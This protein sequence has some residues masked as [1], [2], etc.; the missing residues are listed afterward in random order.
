MHSVVDYRVVY[1]PVEHVA[2]EWQRGVVVEDGFDV[3]YEC[4]VDAQLSR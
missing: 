4:F 3:T 2:T 1:V